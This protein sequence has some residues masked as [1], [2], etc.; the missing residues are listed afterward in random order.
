M[1]Q[2]G[3]SSLRPLSLAVRSTLRP[4]ASFATL[5]PT[6]QLLIPIRAYSS[7]GK[8]SSIVNVLRKRSINVWPQSQLKQGSRFLQ[9]DREGLHQAGRTGISWQRMATT[10][11]SVFIHGIT[12]ADNRIDWRCSRSSRL[13][14]DTKP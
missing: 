5:H 4:T 8:P 11:V 3:L 9:L 14:R 7:L 10:A 6:P 1:L 12:L 2:L 13:R